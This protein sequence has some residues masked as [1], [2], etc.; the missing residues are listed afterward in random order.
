MS[1]HTKTPWRLNKKNGRVIESILG[2][3]IATAERQEDAPLAWDNAAHICH[4][5]NSHDSLVASVEKLRAAGQRWKD[6]WDK[7][8]ATGEAATPEESKAI[9]E[10]MEDA[11]KEGAK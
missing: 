5:V 7:Y 6:A 2:Q 3:K 4:C 8:D 1:E 10:Q 11:L 9:Y